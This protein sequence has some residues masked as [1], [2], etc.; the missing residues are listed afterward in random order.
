MDQNETE[1]GS[2]QDAI[3]KASERIEVK[4]NYQGWRQDNGSYQH[5]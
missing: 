2:N 3:D 1:D 5:D 4:D